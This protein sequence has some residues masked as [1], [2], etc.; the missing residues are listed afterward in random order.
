MKR[1][2]IGEFIGFQP[3]SDA[4]EDVE[5][6]EISDI[7]SP[8]QSDVVAKALSQGL[9]KTDFTQIK[10]EDEGFEKAMAEYSEAASKNPYLVAKNEAAQ[11]RAD[12]DDEIT[13]L[14]R[15]K[16]TEPGF[17]NLHTND[18]E[19]GKGDGKW[20]SLDSN[21]TQHVGEPEI[22]R[23]QAIAQEIEIG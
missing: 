6:I 15:M 8:S 4:G 3:A 12:A 23:G 19:N 21:K 7:G 18:K 9:V 20:Y 22:T 11:T 2:I 10:F 5:T 1:L 17:I 13:L 14:A 16:E